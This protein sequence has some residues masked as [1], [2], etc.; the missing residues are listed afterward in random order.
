MDLSSYSRL[1]CLL[2][3]GLLLKAVFITLATVRRRIVS[4]DFRPIEEDRHPAVGFII[5]YVA[6][7]MLFVFPLGPA[8]ARDQ[9]PP[10]PVTCAASSRSTSAPKRRGRQSSASRLAAAGPATAQVAEDAGLVGWLGAHRNATEQEPFVAATAIAY[11]LVAGSAFSAYAGP[12]LAVYWVSRVLHTLCEGWRLQPWRTISFLV[13]MVTP[14]T[15][16]VLT[17]VAAAAAG[18]SEPFTR[19]IGILAGGLQLKVLLITVGTVQCRIFLQQFIPNLHE[20]A[21]SAG[22]RFIIQYLLKPLVTILPL[23]KTD[24]TSLSSWVNAHR[25]AAEQEPFFLAAVLAYGCW[26]QAPSKLAVQLVYGFLACRIL[27]AAS[28]VLRL[29]PWRTISFLAGLFTMAIFCGLE[30]ADAC[31]SASERRAV[32]ILAAAFGL[33]TV[34]TTLATVRRR[35][36]S[37][38]FRPIEEDTAPAV[39]FLINYV[40]KAMLLVFP[41]GHSQAPPSD[42]AKAQ[43]EDSDLA[44]WLGVHRNST[45]QEFFVLAA[46]VA[47][48]M[49]VAAAPSAAAVSLLF[50]FLALRLCHMASY[51][52]R[53]QPWRTLSFLAAVGASVGFGA[54]AVAA[55]LH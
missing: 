10:E 38:Q 21:E 41:L 24:A 16:G 12:L 22:V 18:P 30:L 6:K 4:G 13:G 51:A 7:A 54:V 39:Q 1:A 9:V 49:V 40:A 23:G 20:D 26:A 48:T 19:S 3:A 45:E 44:A 47:Y 31:T 36:V 11:G 43:V 32:G 35:I 50:A 27:H 52:L 15:L 46:A 17:L 14:A 53:L 5:N 33:K 34:V 28:Y 37:G 55:S 29:Q 25:N 2:C 42:A 8:P